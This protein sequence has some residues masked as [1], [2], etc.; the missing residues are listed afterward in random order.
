MVMS[1]RDYTYK[2][3]LYNSYQQVKHKINYVYWDTT[4][5]LSLRIIKPAKQPIRKQK[6]NV[7]VCS[8]INL[9]NLYLYKI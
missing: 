1:A 3:I 2:K 6:K 8:L 9:C 7:K 4:L 5:N